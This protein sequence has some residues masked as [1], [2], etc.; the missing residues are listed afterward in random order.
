M[1]AILKKATLAAALATVSLSAYAAQTDIK[2]WAEV[3]N[4]LAL[5]KSDG[6]ALPDVVKMAY[7]PVRGLNAWTEQV[8]IFTNEPTKDVD[9]RLSSAAQLLPTNAAPTA[10]AVPLSVSL[11]KK[12]LTSAVQEFKA[13]DLFDGSIPGASISMELS[14]AQTT[15]EKITAA[16]QYEGIVSIILAAKP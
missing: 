13:A 16:G 4:N 5:L 2:V 9:V 7:N 14:I 8:R 3:D 15:Q 1:H 6:S 11:N 12:L 10:A